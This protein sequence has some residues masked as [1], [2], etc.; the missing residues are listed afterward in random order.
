MGASAF[1]FASLGA[2]FLTATE[3]QKAA[4]Q[5]AKA[6]QAEILRQGEIVNVQAAEDKSDAAL[7]MDKA[8]ASARAAMEAIGG[9][10]SIND[11]RV[12]AEIAGLKGLDLARI[13]NNRETKTAS[14]QARAAAVRAGAKAE[15]RSA[16]ISLLTAGLATGGKL[17]LLSEQKDAEENERTRSLD[18]RVFGLPTGQPTS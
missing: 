18:P 11:E 13:E 5:S 8:M 12:Q 9:F 6:Q 16:S 2:N 14:L 1:L 10:G 15:I 17:A 4:A 3:Q 7:R